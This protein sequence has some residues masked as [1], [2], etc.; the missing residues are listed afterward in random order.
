[1]KSARC[2]IKVIAAAA[3]GL[4]CL[5]C[6]RCTMHTRCRARTAHQ[7]GRNSTDD[8]IAKPPMFC[9]L[10]RKQRCTCVCQS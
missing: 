2:R 8:M 7:M 6:R 3:P 1:M 4:R 5:R 10:L 9:A